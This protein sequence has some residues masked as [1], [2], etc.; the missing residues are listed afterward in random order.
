MF[1]AGADV[2]QADK[3]GNTPLFISVQNGKVDIANMLL[4]KEGIDVNKGNNEE[5]S[6]LLKAVYK[7]KTDL[8]NILLQAGADVNQADKNGNTP[9]FISAQN[10]EVDIAKILLEKEGIDINKQ[11]IKGTTALIIA[12]QNGHNDI[13][14]ELIAKNAQLD[15]SNSN[16]QTPLSFA[17]AKRNIDIVKSFVEAGADVNYISSTGDTELIKSLKKGYH[18]VTAILLQA[19]NIDLSLQDNEGRTPLIIAIVKGYE[20]IANKLMDLGTSLDIR[21]VVVNDE[22]F[23]NKKQLLEKI[24]SHLTEVGQEEGS[25][26]SIECPIT[27]SKLAIDG[28]FIGDNDRSS[29]YSTGCGVSVYEEQA[30][31]GHLKHSQRDPCTNQRIGSSKLINM[32]VIIRYYFQPLLHKLR[33][34]LESVNEQELVNLKLTKPINADS[35]WQLS[36]KDDFGKDNNE[37]ISKLPVEKFK[38]LESKLSELRKSSAPS[39]SDLRNQQSYYPVDEQD[40]VLADTT[41][42]EE[43]KGSDPSGMNKDHK[44]FLGKKLKIKKY[45]GTKSF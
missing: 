43:E 1:Q 26:M 22:V 33:K 12:S 44:M 41:F 29:A 16:G 5:I 8:V 36:Y 7:K 38:E 27:F 45:Q 40:K 15:L 23:N 10:G 30:I 19:S 2:N 20:D 11:D 42:Y 28:Y 32:S 13:V 18:D 31:K 34:D 39:V 17:V 3:N 21:E 25:H 9:L 6:P 37:V 35:E 14:K 24:V 4:E